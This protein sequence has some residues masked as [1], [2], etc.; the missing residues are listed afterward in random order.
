MFDRE[1]I[2]LCSAVCRFFFHACFCKV[3]FGILPSFFFFNALC[4]PDIESSGPSSEIRLTPVIWFLWSIS[5]HR[6]EFIDSNLPNAFRILPFGFYFLGGSVRETV[7]SCFWGLI[8]NARI[9]I[10]KSMLSNDNT[11]GRTMMIS[12]RK[13]KE[14]AHTGFN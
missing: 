7:C 2:S 12:G 3:T 10:R 13:K 14:S 9:M 8:H 5:L 1:I 6:S 11:T 4:S